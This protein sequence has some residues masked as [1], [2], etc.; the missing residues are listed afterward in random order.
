MKNIGYIAEKVHS[1]VYRH[2]KYF[3]DVLA[4]EA[5]LKGLAIIAFSMTCFT[6]YHD[7]GKEVHLYHL[8]SVALTCLTAPSGSVEREESRLVGT[9][10]SLWEADEKMAYFGK[11]SCVCGRIG[12]WGPANGTLVNIDHLVQK[13]DTLNALVW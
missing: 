13:G 8:V 6:R 4:L 7:I 1:L 2:V 12:P 9:H 11:D 10:E 5:Y 3:G